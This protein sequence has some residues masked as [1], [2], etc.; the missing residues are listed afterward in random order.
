MEKEDNIL[1]Q[2]EGL[3][4]YFFTRRGV[5]KA[6]DGVSFSVSEGETLG[7]VGESAC[8]K[9]VTCLSILRLVPEPAGRIVGGSIMFKGK[10]LLKKSLAEMR[11][12]RGKEI[13]MI[14]QDPLT[15]LNPAFTIGSQV[16]EVISLH[17][18]L[19]GRTLWQKVIEALKL[20]RI[21]AAET[22]IG[23]YPHQ[24]SGGMRQRVTGAIALSCQPSLLIADEPTTSLDVTIQSQYLR[25]LKELQEQTKT[26][27]IFVTHDF[28][29]VARMCDRVAVMYAGK[30]VETAETREIFDNPRHPY[31]KALMGC[32]PKI[33]VQSQRLTIIKGQ[34]PELSHL[35]PG[36]SFA[37]RCPEASE[38]CWRDYPL[39]RALGRNHDFSCWHT[40]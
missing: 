21:P 39:R 18:K 20:V 6:V 13:S 14:L 40:N 34:P 4:T 35:P 7:L 32:L 29:I 9:S 2:V 37:P 26:S 27:L 36:C 8:G 24:M 31:T 25:L 28:G 22:R 16:A 15:S 33:G 12:I 3:K 11:M 17:Q 19:R 10:N 30:I 1:L 23:D 38:E 5:A